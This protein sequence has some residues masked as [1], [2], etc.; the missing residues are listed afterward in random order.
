[1]EV[2]KRE[3]RFSKYWQRLTPLIGQIGWKPS[4]WVEPQEIKTTQ[5][6]CGWWLCP[7]YTYQ[8]HPVCLPV[9]C[10]KPLSGFGP[11]LLWVV[12]EAEP[13][14]QSGIQL[15]LQ[16]IWGHVTWIPP[17]TYV[18]LGLWIHSWYCQDAGTEEKPSWQWPQHPVDRQQW[19]VGGASLP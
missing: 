9:C 8:F 6:G 13:V 5:L 12:L 15:L 16:L 10:L 14:W 17:V 1:M 2:N 3:L 18:S 7:H 4:V 19:V 11:C